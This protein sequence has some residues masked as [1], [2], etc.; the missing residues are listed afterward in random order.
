MNTLERIK[1]WLQENEPNVLA[2][3]NKPAAESQIKNVESSTG[4]SLPEDYRSFLQTHNGDSSECGLFGGG[5]FLLSCEEII[6]WHRSDAQIKKY[7]HRDYKYMKLQI[8][9]EY[10]CIDGPVVPNLE[11]P[12]WLP[13]MHMDGRVIRYLDFSPASGGTPGQVIET[14]L[15]CWAVLATSFSDFLAIYEEGLLKLGYIHDFHFG[16]GMGRS[17]TLPEAGVPV[18]LKEIT[19]H[20]PTE[21][22]DRDERADWYEGYSP[23]LSELEKQGF[24]YETT[25]VGLQTYKRSKLDRDYFEIKWEQKEKDYVAFIHHQVYDDI[26]SKI[27]PYRQKAIDIKL[28][29]KLEKRCQPN[30][31]K[32]NPSWDGDAW[33]EVTEVSFL[34]KARGKSV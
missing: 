1:L 32:S 12:S 34:G 7:S 16:I 28:Q 23:E 6:D 26:P 30:D 18:W 27:R 15:E 14:D 33:L 3:L 22:N 8:A 21:Y 2:Q 20:D 13:I 25:I 5:H 9:E 24:P 11:H 17:E 19:A 31:P 10:L 29:V 4:I